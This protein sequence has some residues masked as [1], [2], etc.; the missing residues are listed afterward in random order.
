MAAPPRAATRGDATSGKRECVVG[1]LFLFLVAALACTAAPSAAAV[2]RVGDSAGW[3]VTKN[4]NYTAW[5]ASKTFRVGDAVVFEYNKRL[6]DVVEVS[7]SDYRSC[8]PRSPVATHATGNDSVTLGRAGH[9]FFLCG[10]PGHCAL[11]QKVHIRVA[12]PKRRSVASPAPAVSPAS[13]SSSSSPPPSSPVPPTSSGSAG[14]RGAGV[15]PTAQRNGAAP[16]GAGYCVTGWA[17]ATAAMAFV[18]ASG[19]LG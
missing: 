18:A 16:A 11:G 6:H 9:R 8:N 13:S 3:T 4:M 7:K 15:A 14:A 2:Y 19:K 17:L 12:K 10:V 5:A 1:H